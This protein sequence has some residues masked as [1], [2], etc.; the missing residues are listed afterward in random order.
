[1]SS[2]TPALLAL[3]AAVALVPFFRRG[4]AVGPA[5]KPAP[6][7][8][9]AP[10]PSSPAALPPPAE[11]IPPTEAAEDLALRVGDLLRAGRFTDALALAD[12]LPASAEGLRRDCFAAL[13]AS[14]ARARPAEAPALAGLLP[15]H[16][17]DPAVFEAF[18]RGWA[19]SSPAGLA[20][21][22]RTL[23]AGDS[24][25]VALATALE[26]WVLLAPAELADWLPH[27][28]DPA[29][30]DRAAGLLVERTDALHRP[31][32]T[33]LTWAE[34]LADPAL[35]LRALTHVLREWAEQDPAAARGFVESSPCLTPEQRPALRAA[36]RVPVVET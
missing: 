6:V 31:T 22:A 5:A 34:S 2:R 29:E 25:S 23:P 4:P 36:L 18:V 28:T 7:A 13:F 8:M 9:V 16:T 24:R 21:H 15:R 12:T 33:A 32:Q 20:D 26:R 27:L 19:E 14:W 1:M 10:V 17:T 11:N 3:L 35:R 30:F